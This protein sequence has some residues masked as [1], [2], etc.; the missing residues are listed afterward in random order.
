M[1]ERDI[2]DDLVTANHIL[3]NQGVVDGFG[4]VSVR[5]PTRPDRFL[6]SR[7]IAP[8]N[9]KAE[10]IMAFDLDGNPVDAI[11]T[12]GRKPYLERF[13]HS[14]VYRARADVQ[15]VVHNHSPAVI[16][17]GVTNTRLRPIS[18]MSGFL[19]GNVPN[20]EIRDA[21]GPATDMLIRTP[22]L[23]AAF[24]RTLGSAAFALMRGHGAVAVGDSIRQVVY[25]AVYAELNARLQAEAL[26]LGEINFLNDAEA[27]GA[28]AANYA[29]MDRPWE[30][31]KLRAAR[32]L[33]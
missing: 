3:Y 33:G 1:T 21:G 23:G 8:G 31:W 13:I 29:N 5:H 26:C 6:L 32:G 7:S 15:S 24:A 9:V 20:F 10:D 28:D 2:I 19:A 30:L 17:F 11:G 4:H 22:Q 16:P 27:A 14:E 12:S 18:H 25:R